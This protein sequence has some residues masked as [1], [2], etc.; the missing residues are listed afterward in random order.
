MNFQ[1]LTVLVEKN[2][3]RLKRL[4]I[5]RLDKRIAGRVDPSDVIQE[6]FTEASTRWDEFVQDQK[7][8]PFIW[9][10]FLVCQKI[11]TIHRHHL[12]RGKRDA[13][14]EVVFDAFDTSESI[15][16]HLAESATSPSLKVAKLEGQQKLIDALKLL[17]PIDQE[18]LALRHYEGLNNAEVAQAL[19]L[20]PSAAS[21]RYIRALERLRLELGND[22]SGLQLG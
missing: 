7:V 6:A 15:L 3:D 16:A 8:E 17:D 11:V 9:L 22:L 12:G 5:F 10:R 14:R 4:V 1:D 20:T 2:R 19:Q 18:V 21:K 13:N